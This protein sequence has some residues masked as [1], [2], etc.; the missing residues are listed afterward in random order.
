[1]DIGI[2]AFLPGSQIEVRPVRNLEGYIG[3]EIEVR[4]IS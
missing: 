3:T 2:K 1:V 4:V